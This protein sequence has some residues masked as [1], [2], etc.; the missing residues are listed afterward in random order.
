MP[1]RTSERVGGETDAA[2]RAVV[3]RYR[4]VPRRRKT[5]SDEEAMLC[6]A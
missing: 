3:L 5:K 1:F 2:R 6:A 4:G